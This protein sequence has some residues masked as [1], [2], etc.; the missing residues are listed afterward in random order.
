MTPPIRIVKALDQS[1]SQEEIKSMPH[2]II[3]RKNVVLNTSEL[4]KEDIREAFKNDFPK[5]TIK[6]SIIPLSVNQCW[7]GRRFKSD[8]Y[9][10]YE[11][12]MLFLLPKMEIP[13]APYKLSIKVGFSN[14]LSDLD[15][16]NK[17][18]QDILCKKYG[19]NDRDI[20]ELHL[21]KEIVDKGKE[22]ISFKIESL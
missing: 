18:F 2:N 19:F 8:K 15:N 21:M 11:R 5:Y 16:I 20:Y 1:P 4:N 9:K 10:K 7:Q 3:R 14:K 13:T 17:P 12:D 22:Y 6:I